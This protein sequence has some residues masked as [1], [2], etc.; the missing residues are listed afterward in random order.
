M[1]IDGDD[2]QSIGPLS[3]AERRLSRCRIGSFA[4]GVY[5][6]TGGIPVGSTYNFYVLS[7]SKVQNKN[8]QELHQSWPI[9][10]AK[11]DGGPAS[12]MAQ[13]PPGADHLQ[14]RPKLIGYGDDLRPR[15][16]GGQFLAIP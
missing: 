15:D 3:Y 7:H 8:C 13:D 12:L 1:D 5:L 10:V 6:T 4:T 9:Y 14:F 11:S 2:Q 16:P